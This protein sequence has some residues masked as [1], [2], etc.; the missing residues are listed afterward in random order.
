MLIEAFTL[1][2][3]RFVKLITKETEK[4]NSYGVTAAEDHQRYMNHMARIG[5]LQQTC[6]A[7]MQMIIVA[8]QAIPLIPSYME[9]LTPNDGP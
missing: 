2:A 6:L 5:V 9:E 1:E 4:I 8:D 3:D 7:F